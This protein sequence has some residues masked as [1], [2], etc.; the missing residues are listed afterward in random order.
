MPLAYHA[1]APP[2]CTSFLTQ[3]GRTRIRILGIRPKQMP[4]PVALHQIPARLGGV[5]ATLAISWVLCSIL[6]C[7]TILGFHAQAKRD[8][9]SISSQHWRYNEQAPGQSYTTS[10][11]ATLASHIACI[12]LST[13]A[14]LWH[15]RNRSYVAVYV[16]ISNIGLRYTRNRST[17]VV[18]R[19]LVGLMGS[20]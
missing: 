20:P 18:I 9:T 2:S 11:S 16:S 6:Q 10:A 12:C 19:I 4:P 17:Y 1:L 15:K 8:T 5:R 3:S 13:L 7:S 14:I